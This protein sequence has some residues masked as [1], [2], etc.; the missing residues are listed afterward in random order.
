MVI[1]T[2]SNKTEQFLAIGDRDGADTG[3]LADIDAMRVQLC[4]LKPCI[5]TPTERSAI[6][7]ALAEKAIE[8]FSSV[9]RRSRIWRM[10]S[11]APNELLTIIGKAMWATKRTA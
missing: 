10:N 11:A 9:S 5:N 8:Y 2:H 7:S 3:L 4:S 1:R 6:R